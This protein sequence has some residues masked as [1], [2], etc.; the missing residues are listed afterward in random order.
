ML[1]Y[2]AFPPPTPGLRLDTNTIPAPAPRDLSPATSQPDS[3]RAAARATFEE[4]QRTAA[5]LRAQTRAAALASEVEWVRAGGTLRDA[6]GRRDKV[7]TERIRAELKL[8]A[9]ERRV[10]ARWDAHE[11]AWGALVA[12][13]GGVAFGDIPWPVHGP[14]PMPPAEGAAGMLGV[15]AIAGFLF[16]SLGLRGNTVSRR[17]RIRAALLRWHPDKLGGVVERVVPDEL[18]LVKDCI[19]AVFHSLKK[20]QEQERNAPLSL[21]P[22]PSLLPHLSPSY[23]SLSSAG[24]MGPGRSAHAVWDGVGSG[25][26]RAAVFSRPHVVSELLLLRLALRRERARTSSLLPA[27]DRGADRPALAGFTTCS[28]SGIVDL[29]SGDVLGWTH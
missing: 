11:R 12:S 18:E 15:E 22:S 29:W 19:N 9:E 8:Q 4:A 14:L 13:E 5:Q 21:P 25:R 7:R 16:E 28:H 2:L 17:E 26:L 1:G 20:M 23:L 27:P 10:R 24:P 6:Q 3:S